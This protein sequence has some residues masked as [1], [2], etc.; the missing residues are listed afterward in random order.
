MALNL[1]KIYNQLLELFGTEAQIRS[2]L[3]GV[4]NKDFNAQQE[5]K[6]NNK[7]V[8][9]TPRHDGE[10]PMETLFRHLTTEITDKKTRKREFEPQRSLR[11]HWVKYH[12]N[13]KKSNNML[14][15]S[16]KEPEGIRTYFYDRDEKYVVVLEP[17]RNGEAYYLLTAYNV[18]GKDGLR[19][20][21]EKK[22]NRRIKDEVL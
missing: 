1:L 12:L 3:K 2:S 9:P 17:Q 14:L 5:I 18:R 19:N 4:F 21:M 11:L 7:A 16:V 22:Y 20:K 10:I 6:F 15:F 8:Y 13:E